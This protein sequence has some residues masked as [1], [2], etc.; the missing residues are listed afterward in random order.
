MNILSLRGY[1][2][3]TVSRVSRI[4]ICD[5]TDIILGVMVESLVF[6]L[7]F[8]HFYRIPLFAINTELLK[9]NLFSI[10]N[11]EGITFNY[12]LITIIKHKCY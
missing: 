11:S 12:T 1:Q 2:S 9:C 6:G 7:H 3:K 4:Q 8:K 10:M 5:N